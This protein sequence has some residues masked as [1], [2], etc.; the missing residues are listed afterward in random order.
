MLTGAMPVGIE[1]CLYAA[2]D[3]SQHRKE[4]EM[5]SYITLAA[6]AM[7]LVSA[8]NTVCNDSATQPPPKATALPTIFT[9]H[10]PLLL[11]SQQ[12]I[13]SV[14]KDKP[15][16]LEINGARFPS[17]QA[18]VVN[19]R[20]MFPLRESL[21][22][23][24]ASVSWNEWDQTAKVTFRDKEIEFTV[25]SKVCKSNGNEVEMDV[26]PFK[27]GGKV[28][29]SIR[30]AGQALG[31]AVGL[32]SDDDSD[33]VTLAETPIM[34]VEHGPGEIW[35]NTPG[36]DRIALAGRISDFN[37][38]LSLNLNVPTYNLDEGRNVFAID[39][40]VITHI[41]PEEGLVEIK[42][43]TASAVEVPGV[44]DNLYT[45]FGSPVWYSI[46]A[47]MN[48]SPG[49]KVGQTVG[50]GAIIGTV[51]NTNSSNDDK[52][53]KHLFFAV[54]DRDGKTFSPSYFSPDYAS[55]IYGSGTF[56]N[57]ESYR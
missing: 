7:A 30:Y 23:L 34:P 48:L 43:N 33:T 55:I 10:D 19:G 51:S 11:S 24:G 46:Y 17:S 22:L 13:V 47:R 42:H 50:K 8:P 26:A 40:G 4:S 31:F 36:Q 12:T 45:T 52:V 35:S 49:L 27:S 41:I 44:S 3:A 15:I 14:E 21:E 6:I 9:S 18:R 39:Y 2:G 54:Y 5:R 20:Y 56:A 57:G 28:Y 1:M 32:H 25:G 29:I 37:Y 38:A 16:A 53:P